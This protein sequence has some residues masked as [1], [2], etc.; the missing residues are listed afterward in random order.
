MNPESQLVWVE[1][2]KVRW[3]D[4]DALGHVNNTVYFR[5]M[6]HARISWFDA[7]GIV[8]TAA[9]GPVMVS[10]SCNFIKA[11]VYPAEI[12][13][14]VHC[15]K[16]G[17]SSFPVYHKIYAADDQTTRYADGETTLVWVDHGSGKSMPL[18]PYLRAAIERDGQADIENTRRLP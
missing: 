1:K 12:A 14:S 17:R 4:M 8:V 7:L 10:A 9:Q 3:G 11:I 13:I 18:P 15:G 5:Y 16:L 2:T 6:E